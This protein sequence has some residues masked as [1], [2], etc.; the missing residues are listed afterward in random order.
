M[1]SVKNE[2]MQATLDTLRTYAGA[3]TDAGLATILGISRERLRQWRL[4]EVYDVDVIRG[5]FPELSEEWLTTGEGL[6]FTPEGVDKLIP[7]LDEL[8]ALL[9]AKDAI[10]QQQQDHIA[11]LT[12][13]LTRS[14]IWR[15]QKI[16][17][18]CRASEAVVSARGLRYVTQV[19]IFALG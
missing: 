15:Y 5:V 18:L 1:A 3:S 12:L 10:I 6:P 8:R 9:L 17:Y 14:S 2:N 4:R 19:G 16:S 7:H 13:A 11:K